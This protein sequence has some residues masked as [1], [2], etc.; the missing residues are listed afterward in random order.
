MWR[1]VV[2]QARILLTSPWNY[3]YHGF[4]WLGGTRSHCSLFVPSY[5]TIVVPGLFGYG[6]DDP[7]SRFIPY[8]DLGPN[9][10]TL[11][12]GPF[13]SLDDRVTRIR[14]TLRKNYPQMSP[15][16]PVDLVGHSLGANTVLALLASDPS[17][18]LSVRRVI[19]I[20]GVLGGYHQYSKISQQGKA[21]MLVWYTISIFTWICDHVLPIIE[22]FSGDAS[23]RAFPATQG[24][25]VCDALPIV[26]QARCLEGFRAAHA[27]GVEIRILSTSTTID[28]YGGYHLPVWN[29]SNTL[30]VIFSYAMGTHRRTD[31]ERGLTDDGFVRG[32]HDGVVLC[33]SQESLPLEFRGRYPIRRVPTYGHIDGFGW[34]PNRALSNL[35]IEELQCT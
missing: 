3:L 19:L 20:G 26:C 32:P 16:N 6:T 22:T 8:M 33:S 10:H 11:Q 1:F 35:I 5:H 31:H 21:T 30:S 28:V 25:L 4:Y 34:W 12:A 27:A 23:V 24:T 13:S 15:E 14:H 9:V 17:L 29:I 18:A 2:E 7:L